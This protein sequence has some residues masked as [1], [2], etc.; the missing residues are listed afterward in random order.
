MYSP[1]MSEEEFVNNL[2]DLPIYEETKSHKCFR[3]ILKTPL[4]I[5][6]VEGLIGVLHD[7][8]P[9]DSKEYK[10][11]FYYI[12]EYFNYIYDNEYVLSIPKANPFPNTTDLA[13]FENY[14]R[15][16]IINSSPSTDCII[17]RIGELKYRPRY[18]ME[19]NPNYIH[20]VVGGLIHTADD[21][22]VVLKRKYGQ[23]K[24]KYTMVQGHCSYS[25]A[26]WPKF[27][28][29]TTLLPERTNRED[30]NLLYTIDL[31]REIMEEVGCID[32]TV[33]TDLNLYKMPT[34]ISPTLL[35]YYHAGF[36]FY[37]TTDYHDA[38]FK[39]GEPDRNEI[40]FMTKDQLLNLKICQTDMWLHEYVNRY[41]D[42]I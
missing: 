17:K 27:Y 8:F 1:G 4:P 22:Y 41:D 21:H 29:I 3:D 28:R 30:F 31:K 16:D 35:S 20:F 14:A 13:F 15:Y 2:L 9:I 6:S 38:D 12:R 32:C 7:F 36:L 26:T 37:V 33:H 23:F 34:Y 19:W 18:E 40:V 42:D 24:D 10:G 25:S 5:K 39:A 11:I